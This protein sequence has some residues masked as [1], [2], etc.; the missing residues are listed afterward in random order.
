[1]NPNDLSPEEKLVLLIMYEQEKLGNSP[2]HKTVLN[3]LLND[4]L[5]E[6]GGSIDAAIATIQKRW[7]VPKTKH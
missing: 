2:I 7:G 5:Q 3:K 6:A 4:K 1:M